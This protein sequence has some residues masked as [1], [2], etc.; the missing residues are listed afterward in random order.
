MTENFNDYFSNIGQNLA[1]KIVLNNERAYKNYLSKSVSSSMFLEPTS[2]LEVKQQIYSL[3]SKKSSGPDEISAHF[4]VVAANVLAFPLT[5]LFNYAFEFGIFP[6]CLKTAKVI[7]IFKSGIKTDISNYR[8]ISILSYFSKNFEKLVCK[9]TRS[10]LDKNSV[11]LPTQYGFRPLYSTS[12]AMLDLLTTSL[13]NINCNKSTALILLDL[14]KAFDTLNHNIL[15][16][17]LLHYGIRRTANSLFASF[18]SNRYQYVSLNGVKST[19]KSIKCGVPQGSVL[20]PLLFT[21]Y[22]NDISNCT[23]CDPRLFAD[24]T[25]LILH[26]DNLLALNNLVTDEVNAVNKWMNANK[27][28]LNVSKSNII[29]ISSSNNKSKKNNNFASSSVDSTT[30]NLTRITT[31][32]AKYLGVTFDNCLSFKTHINT[33]EKTLSRAVGILAKVKP[34]LNKKA[35]L[36]LYYAIF[37]SHLQ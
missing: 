22:I 24:D 17:K 14:K 11:L 37:H 19:T 3:S 34:F 30:S 23:T 20:G 28:T 36:L 29:V 26:N 35:M 5:I 8:P 4:L 31:N 15:I 7:P 33:L 18:L 9:R 10:F 25:C 13:D 2:H 21:L 1:S 16:N 12:H 32:N 27:L 6:S